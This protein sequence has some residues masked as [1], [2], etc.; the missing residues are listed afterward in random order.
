MVMASESAFDFPNF[1]I[2]EADFEPVDH[3]W[4]PEFG[5]C[6]RCD[7]SPHVQDPPKGFGSWAGS[8]GLH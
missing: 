5:L 2:N 1:K 4:N 6:C 3:V 7:E 8:A